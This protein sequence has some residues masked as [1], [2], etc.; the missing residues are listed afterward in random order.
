MY[1]LEAMEVVIL[2]HLNDLGIPS[3]LV[4]LERQSNFDENEVDKLY[5]AKLDELHLFSLPHPTF[6]LRSS[7]QLIG[8]IVFPLM[9]GSESSAW[10]G[11]W[12]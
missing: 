9:R 2:S 1:N 8:S 4:G 10:G 6:Q 12:L 3:L 5:R 11:L 7:R